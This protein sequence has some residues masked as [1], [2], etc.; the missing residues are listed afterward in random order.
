MPTNSVVYSATKTLVYSGARADPRTDYECA[1]FPTVDGDAH[2]G[3]RRALRD[4][5]DQAMMARNS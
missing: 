4:D 5:A 2:A 3:L 1:E